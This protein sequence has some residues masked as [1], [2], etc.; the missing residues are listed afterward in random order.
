MQDLDPCEARLSQPGGVQARCQYLDPP[1]F[2]DLA[3]HH[4]G[5]WYGIWERLIED[6]GT[7]YVEKLA[8][9]RCD[10]PPRLIKEPVHSSN[11]PLCWKDTEDAFQSTAP[12]R[13]LE[14]HLQVSS[15]I[16][17]EKKKK[18]KN[19]KKK[20]K[21]KRK[22][23]NKNNKKKSPVLALWSNQEVLLSVVPPL[24]SIP[25]EI[26]LIG[27][28]WPADGLRG[29]FRKV[30][31]SVPWKI[32]RDG[33]GNTSAPR[34]CSWSLHDQFRRCDYPVHRAT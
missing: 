13:L 15:R 20:K 5:S 23:E 10:L 4:Q 28:L 22:K 2:E 26:Q 32:A 33:A 3:R 19:N 16:P 25:Q 34:S 27:D 24:L 1:D 31:N 18:K 9:L 12:R 8:V 29:N 14:H 11:E 6:D 7:L 17:V 30:T 21:K